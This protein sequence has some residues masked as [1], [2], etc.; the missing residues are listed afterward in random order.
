MYTLTLLF[1]FGSCSSI[2]SEEKRIAPSNISSRLPREKPVRRT[3]L[4]LYFGDDK[5]MSVLVLLSYCIVSENYSTVTENI[6]PNSL[7]LQKLKCFFFKTEVV[8]SLKLKGG[9]ESKFPMRKYFAIPFW[10]HWCK[11]LLKDILLYYEIQHRLDLTFPERK[12]AVM[13]RKITV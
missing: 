8:S 3:P 9:K 5:C 12:K 4:V 7:R 6:I 2:G 11:I 10:K 13:S 1:A